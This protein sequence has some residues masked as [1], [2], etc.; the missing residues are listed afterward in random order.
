MPFD[1]YVRTPV[2][3]RGR[4]IE[5]LDRLN[6]VDD[7]AEVGGQRALEIPQVDRVRQFKPSVGAICA[8]LDVVGERVVGVQ[9]PVPD[10]EVVFD[11]SAGCEGGV[12][13]LRHPRELILRN[14]VRPDHIE[15]VI[16]AQPSQL[17]T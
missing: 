2:K 11:L 10:I 16:G 6:D 8:D 14:R 3:A 7:V 17:T 13:D 4:R 15:G 12:P 1:I 5:F 9:V